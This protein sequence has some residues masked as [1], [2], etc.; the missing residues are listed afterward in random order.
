[1]LRRP[2]ASL[3]CAIVVCAAAGSA[4]AEELKI[5]ASRAVGTVLDVVGPEFQKTSG[6]SLDVTTGLSPEFIKRINA[7]EPFDIIAVPAAGIDALIKNGKVVADSK[8]DLVRS[9]TGVVI[10]AGAPKPDISSVDAFK[11]TLLNAKSI[12]QLPVPGVPQLVERLGLKEAIASKLTVPDTDVCSELVAKGK[13][14]L[15]VLVTTQALTTPGVELA[16]QL[17]P[18]IAF[19]TDFAGGISLESK[20]PDAARD[21]LRFLKGPTAIPV[22]KSQGMQPL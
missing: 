1:M 20:A 5:F 7:K 11:R 10:R 8:V 4:A 22:I 15:T 13:I 6:H 12:C 21:L 19:N 14:E 9:P 17:P 3:T 18:E 16:G 2:L